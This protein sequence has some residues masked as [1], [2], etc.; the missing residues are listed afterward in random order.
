MK[1]D[2]ELVF[3][4]EQDFEEKGGKGHFKQSTVCA[5]SEGQESSHLFNFWLPISCVSEESQPAY[6]R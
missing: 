1:D 2:S 6:K 3:Q 4:D 5:R